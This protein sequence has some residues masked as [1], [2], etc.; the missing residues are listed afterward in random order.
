MSLITINQVNC[1]DCYKCVRYCPVKAIRVVGGHAEVVEERCLGDGSCLRICPQHAK[2]VRGDVEVVR[3]LL[4]SGQ[5]V[6]ASIAPAAVGVFGADYPRLLGAVKVLG[7]ARVEE[8]ARTAAAVARASAALTLDGGLPV[9]TSACPAVVALVEKYYP[10]YVPLLAAVPSPMMAHAR[11]LREEYGAETPVVFIGPCVAK[12]EEG[13]RDGV[14]AALTFDELRAWLEEE[15]IVLADAAPSACDNAPVGVAEIFPILSGLLITAG[16]TDDAV[17]PR[18]VTVAGLQEIR[19]MLDALP[20]CSGVRLI[21]ALACKGGCLAGP[22]AAEGPE[23]WARREALLTHMHGEGEGACP[24]SLQRAFTTPPLSLPAPSDEEITAVLRRTGKHTPDDEQNCG[25]CGYDSCREKAVAV[26]QGMAEAEMCIPYM[27]SRAESVAN[28]IIS[29]TPNAIVVADEALR[30]L[31]VNPAFEAIFVRP[32]AELL[33]RPLDT[34]LDNS[35]YERVQR[36]GRPFGR[37]QVSYGKKTLREMIFPGRKEDFIIG[38]YV[39]VTEEE[40]HREQLST[41]KRETLRQARQ[42]IDKQMR[43]AQEIAGLLGETTA[44]TKVLLTRLIQLSN[45]EDK[46][47]SK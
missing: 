33:G 36:S 26:L 39:D 7:F 4:A 27:R 29:S 22:G 11:L 10:Q 37:H 41:V 1:K 25:A 12:K 21:E 43:V 13:Q 32:Q 2:H 42:V 44:E 23:F 34:V 14:D 5:Q 40:D 8:T 30:I 38:I 19:E 20:E 35:G 18:V 16:V 17:R 28:I 15:Q 3:G 6:M 46:T 31:S 45:E 9:I 24:S 47:S